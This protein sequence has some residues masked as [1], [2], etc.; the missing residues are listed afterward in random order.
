MPVATGAATVIESRRRGRT[1]RL[2]RAAGNGLL[3]LSLLGGGALPASAHVAVP[4]PAIE[5]VINT[6]AELAAW[7]RAEA[8]AR[9]VAEG[10]ATFQWSASHHSRGNTLVV[11]GR[12]R[13]EGTDYLVDCRIARGAREHYGSIGITEDSIR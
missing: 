7:C 5:R 9:F 12:L 2:H 4:A 10:R 8:E 3:V 11:S 1:Y 6:G 13:V